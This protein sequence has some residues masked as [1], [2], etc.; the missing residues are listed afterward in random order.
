[1]VPGE[2][3]LATAVVMALEEEIQL[4]HVGY[5]HVAPCVL[6]VLWPEFTVHGSSP[7]AEGKL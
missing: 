5:V 4:L 1:M 7:A 6:S 3:L 2:A